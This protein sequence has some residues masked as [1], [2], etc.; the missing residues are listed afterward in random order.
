MTFLVRIFRFL[1]WV[2]ILSWSLAILRRL[3][4]NMRRGMMRPTEPTVDVQ[5]DAVT[6]TLVRD[7]VCGL[8]VAEGLALPVRAG[9]ET[10]YF[11][12]AECRD[13]YVKKTQKLAANS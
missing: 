5:S 7:P 11:C 10:L 1:F 6:R 8:H 9:G 3:V 4:R 13:K 2:L 12:S